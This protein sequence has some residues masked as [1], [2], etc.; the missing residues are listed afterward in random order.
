[1][2]ET[3]NKA[4]AA[5][6]EAYPNI[7][8]EEERVPYGDLPQKVQ[9]YVS[10][11]DAPDI[12]MG[13]NDFASAYSA[14]E[15]ALPLN[16]FF[17]ED[18]IIDIYKPL[19]DS[20]TIG[21]S[22]LCV[23]WETN[24][25]LIYFNREIFKRAGVDTP[26]E[27]TD[28]HEGWNVEQYINALRAVTDALRSQGDESTFG[29]QASMHGGGGPGSNYTQLECIWV[30]M[31]GDPNADP[32]SSIYRTFAAVSADG[33]KASGYL[34]TPEAAAGMTN[35]Q[36]LFTEGLTP[37]G[38]VPD[39]YTGG[40][41]ATGFGSLNWANRFRANGAPFD[42]GVT[43]APRGR[44]VYNTTVADSPFVWSGTPHANEA[45]ALLAFIVGDTNRLAFHKAWGSMPSRASL[46]ALDSRYQTDQVNQLVVSV[47]DG[48][49]GPP[50][51]PG[52]FD[53]FNA[54]NPA[55]KDI[56][57]GADPAERLSAAAKQIDGLLAKYR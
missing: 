57:L 50:K 33:L 24:P 52:W 22:L 16:D 53:Y 20:A 10:S 49:Y 9:V 28:I 4:Y 6:M 39:M 55:V 12:M 30:R 46:V 48:A 56:A 18:Y 26:P 41:A 1:V 40:V 47:A 15:L 38:I 51:T 17:S 43:P 3:F 27:V 7:T 35:Y 31:M 36:T 37:K 29:L 13:R 5:F 23:P 25:T 54:V 45:A 21:G 14:G 8:V 11:G 44:I 42:W 34:D 2:N 19:R 32:E